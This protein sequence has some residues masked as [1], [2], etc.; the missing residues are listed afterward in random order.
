MS[1]PA[2][3]IPNA[4]AKE[5][6][7]K[8]IKTL[9]Q[10]VDASRA[11]QSVAFR[12]W[13]RDTPIGYNGPHPAGFVANRIGTDLLIRFRCGIYLYKP[14]PAKRKGIRKGFKP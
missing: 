1:S 6:I 8:Q 10:L 12:L 14:K 11:K 7:G 5:R 9:E 2:R 4:E 13:H 3:F